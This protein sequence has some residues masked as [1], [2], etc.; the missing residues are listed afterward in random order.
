MST[1]VA[2]R[3]GFIALAGVAADTGV[4]MLIHLDEAF[5]RRRLDGQLRSAPVRFLVCGMR[6]RDRGADVR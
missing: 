3:V 2:V 1:S 5:H 4:V 6:W